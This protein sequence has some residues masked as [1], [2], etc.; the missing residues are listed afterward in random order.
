GL[1]QG[2]EAGLAY[3]RGAAG[4][5]AMSS[6][7]RNLVGLFL[8][9]EAAR[10]LPAELRALAGEPIRHVGVVGAGAMGA[11]IAQL[12]AFKDCEVVVQEI[13]EA[14]LGAGLIKVAGLFKKAVERRLLTREEADRKLS[15]VRGTN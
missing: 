3:E 12:S 9:R 6:A 2:M 8:Q 4:R 7:C 14:A 11:G 10:K 13:D 1:S 15:A 5:L